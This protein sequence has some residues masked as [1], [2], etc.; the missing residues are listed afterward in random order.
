MTPEQFFTA[1][2]TRI[3]C[4]AD[5]GTIE[6]FD[7]WARWEQGRTD[8]DYWNPLNT[9]QHM[10]GSKPLGGDPNQNGG[11]PVQ[12]Y[13]DAETGIQATVKTLANG[14]YPAV[15]TTI[16]TR[17]VQPDT[18][19]QIRLWGTTGFANALDGGWT[20]PAWKENDTMEPE[21]LKLLHAADGPYPAMDQAYIWL[22]AS[23]YFQEWIAQDGEPADPLAERECLRWLASG[24]RAAEAVKALN[25]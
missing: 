3:Q 22:R 19:R 10:P 13:S 24:D 6:F 1:V 25:W 15:L 12:E 14:Y 7:E 9:T 18:A 2:A 21:R 11:N 20:P 17:V 16:R 23:G 4:P 5:A 8:L